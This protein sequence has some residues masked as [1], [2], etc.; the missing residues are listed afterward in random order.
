M[1]DTKEK[2]YTLRIPDALH[3]QL[4]RQAKEDR[5]SLHTFIIVTLEAAAQQR[6]TAQREAGKE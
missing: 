6:D 4:T 5:R 1:S 3:A 2:K